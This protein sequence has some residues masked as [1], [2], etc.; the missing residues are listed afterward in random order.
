MER[1]RLAADFFL[2]AH[3]E[4]TGKSRISAPLL[5][6]GL[7][8]AQL[9]ELLMAERI[10]VE[11]GRLLVTDTRRA[12]GDAV[13]SYIVE[14]VQV[15][16]STHSVRAWVDTFGDV[17]P[18]LIARQ[19]VVEGV[20]RHEQGGRQLMRRRPDRYPAADL[21]AAARPRLHLEHLLRT[22]H[23]FDL[24][25]AVLAVLVGVVSTESLLDPALDRAAA[26]ELIGRLATHLPADL[27]DLVEGVKAAVAAISLAALR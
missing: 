11:S 17:L 1:S 19:L 24:S 9:A 25:G 15:Q 13:G 10:A 26:R 12:E 8:G 7:A 14:S 22:P 27:Q 6:C 4:F 16:S 21:L 20:V 2:I 23:D 18:E 5:G 3:D